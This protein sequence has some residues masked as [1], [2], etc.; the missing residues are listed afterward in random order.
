MNLPRPTPRTVL[1][2]AVLA[3]VACATLATRLGAPKDSIRVPHATHT[4]AEVDCTS[5]HETI[6]DST[7]NKGAR[8]MPREK[9]CLECHK[10]E[11]EEKHNCGFCHSLPEKPE[12][13]PTRERTLKMN[14]STHMERVKEDCSV[15][16]KDL[17]NP[18]RTEELA[19]PMDTCLG[20]H[21]HQEHFDQGKCDVCHEDLTK[22]PLKPIS[23]YSHGLD[24]LRKHRL[25]ARSVGNQVCATCHEQS[26]CGDCHAKTL[27]QKPERLWSER[28]D[29]G[30]IHRADFIGRHPLEAQADQSL[31]LRC[32]GTSFCQDCHQREGLTSNSSRPLKPHPAGFGDGKV[33][34]PAARRDIVTC[35][36]CHDQGAA[37]NCV[38]CHKVGGVGGSPHPASWILRHPSSEIRS[39]AMC[40][41]CHAN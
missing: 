40:Q 38:S 1:P 39:N 41:V 22:Y 27:D 35:A 2:V 33:H 16:H 23:N 21:E 28:V 25:E 37:S 36:A 20:C 19:P 34:G 14:H 7:E 11:K 17:P 31:C 30:F 29:R 5:C 15:C 18:W 32:H 3:L 13:V 4:K 8:D 6:F 12:A 24:F 10:E 26:F 9:K